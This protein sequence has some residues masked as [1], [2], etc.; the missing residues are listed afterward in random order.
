[1]L[2]HILTKKIT[3]SGPY[4]PKRTEFFAFVAENGYSARKAELSLSDWE[5]LDIAGARRD[6]PVVILSLPSSGKRNL[7]DP[8]LQ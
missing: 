3:S 6:Y 2:E 1:M 4:T 5:S 7:Q 8:Q